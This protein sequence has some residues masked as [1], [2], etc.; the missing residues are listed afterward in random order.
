ML[1]GLVLVSDLNSG[2]YVSGYRSTGSAQIGFLHSFDLAATCGFKVDQ[3][4]SIP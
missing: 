1:L 2:L 4:E 3:C